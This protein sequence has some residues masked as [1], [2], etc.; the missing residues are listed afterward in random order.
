M[1]PTGSRGWP[2]RYPAA[3]VFLTVQRRVQKHVRNIRLGEPPV[4]GLAKRFL[5][6]LSLAGQ[7]GHQLPL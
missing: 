7:P 6:V 1:K 5:D 4:D 2:R 3:A